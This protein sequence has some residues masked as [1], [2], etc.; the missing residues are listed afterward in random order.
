MHIFK[1]EQLLFRVRLVVAKRSLVSHCQNFQ[2]LISLFMLVVANAEM[3]WPKYSV[4]F[5]S[6]KLKLMAER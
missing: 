4:T 3:K 6:L 1:V 5:P 2:I